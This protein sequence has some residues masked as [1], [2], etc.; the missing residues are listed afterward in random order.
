MIRFRRP[1]LDEAAAL[2]ALHVQ[3]WREAYD[4]IVPLE[5]SSKFD[6]GAKLA[7]WA[8]HLSEPD[9]FILAA[10]DQEIVVGFVNQ[11]IADEQTVASA[12]GYVAAL[13]IAASHH[14]KGIGRRLLARAAEDWM[15]RGGHAFSL[16]VLAENT[17][18]RAFYERLGGRVVKSGTYMWHGHGLPDVTYVFDNLPA[19][20]R[21]N[22]ET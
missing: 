12:D 8:R 11:A 21:D 1:R 3:C 6:V 9:R 15:S 13:Y 5:V 4:S 10:Y 16:G 20:V 17:R 19:L 22:G 2:A 14:R 18:A 7:D